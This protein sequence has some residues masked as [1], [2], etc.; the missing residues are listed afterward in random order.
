MKMTKTTSS[1]S[2]PDPIH[3]APLFGPATLLF[4][5]ESSKGAKPTDT[6]ADLCTRVLAVAAGGIIGRAGGGANPTAVCGERRASAP[7][8]T[9]GWPARR[10]ASAHAT[11]RRRPWPSSS[12]AAASS[13]AGS[14]RAASLCTR[15]SVCLR[16]AAPRGAAARRRAGPMPS[17]AAHGISL[18]RTA[19]ISPGGSPSR[20]RGPHP[21][22]ER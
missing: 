8:R 15:W 18:R 9:R 21:H 3:P 14:A 22:P 1:R 5:A 12:V 6:H 4:G 20:S 19:G 7:P 16:Q 17:T 2:R 11:R 13:R 10:E